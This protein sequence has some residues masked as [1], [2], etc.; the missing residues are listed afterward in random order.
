L[1]YYIYQSLI[2]DNKF[3]IVQRIIDNVGTKE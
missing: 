2:K 3:L 1:S